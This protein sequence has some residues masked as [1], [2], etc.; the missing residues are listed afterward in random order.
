MVLSRIFG[1]LIFDRIMFH[2]L[3]HFA[4]GVS[5]K[6][7]SGI[8]QCVAIQQRGKWFQTEINSTFAINFSH[9]SHNRAARQPVR[10]RHVSP[11]KNVSSILLSSWIQF[12]FTPPQITIQVGSKPFRLLGQNPMES[13]HVSDLFPQQNPWFVMVYGLLCIP[14]GS[15]FHSL[16]WEIHPL[17]KMVNPGRPSISIR[18]MASMAMFVI[19]RGYS[20]WGLLAFNPQMLDDG[21]A[22]SPFQCSQQKIRYPRYPQELWHGGF[23]IPRYPFF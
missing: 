13:H 18:A 7:G 20:Y 3:L 9:D 19:T 8:P 16:P 2:K 22:H 11:R 10:S 12:P 1:L 15:D 4:F 6:K 5:P 21:N 23:R 17:L 14:S